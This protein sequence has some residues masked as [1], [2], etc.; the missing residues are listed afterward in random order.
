MPR[1][2][3][4]DRFCHAAKPAD[5]EVQTDYYDATSPGLAL[6]VSGRSKTWTYF[7]TLSGKRHRMSL[8]TYPAT[9]LARAH[10]LTDEA[11]AELEGGRDPRLALA[12]PDTL[13]GICEEWVTREAKNLRTGARRSADLTRLV[14]PVLGSRPISDLLR[15]DIVRLLDRI[16]DE[17]G[18][19]MADKTLAALRRVFNWH[20]SRSDNFR[21]PIVRGMARTK[22]SERA[23]ARILTDDELRLVWRTAEGQGTFGRLIRFLLLTGARRS[24]AAGMRWSELAEDGEWLLPAARNKTKLDLLRPLSKQ[25]VAVLGPRSGELVFTNNGADLMGSFSILKTAFD[26]A[27]GEPIP[28]WTLH[29]L[30]RTARSLLSR[31]GV[32]TDHAERVLGHVIGGVRG[33]YDRY[34]YR[35]EK[36]DALAKLAVQINRILHPRPTSVTL[37]RVAPERSA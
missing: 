16:E 9:S 24:E 17:Q 20:A 23:R 14:Y 15:S 3:L 1:R 32:P 2:S 10:T 13:R 30:R 37:Q 6:R 31:A 29:D 8:G 34:S 7:Y 5:G 33:T 25:A 35:D 26:R 11:K 4:T 27:V 19:A 12:K 18:P 28:N 22:P 36:A 21:S